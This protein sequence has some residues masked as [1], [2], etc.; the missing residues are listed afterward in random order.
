MRLAFVVPRFGP[1]VVGGVETHVRTLAEHLAARG[2]EAHVLTTTATDHYTWAPFHPEGTEVTGGVTVQRFDP[3]TTRHHGRFLEV[4]ARLS[5][6]APLSYLEQLEWI[7]QSVWSPG[8]QHHLERNADG[9]DWIVCAPYL[10]GTSYWATQV[11]PERTVHIPCVHDEPFAY[12]DVIREMLEDARGCLF[13][14]P[15]EADLALRLAPGIRRHAIGGLGFDAREPSPAAERRFLATNDLEPGYLFYAGRREPGKGIPRL[16]ELYGRLVAGRGRETTPPLVVA[17]RG[18]FDVPRELR[19]HV[20]D[21]GFLTEDEKWAA[22]RN[23]L[24]LVM[25]SRL[26]SLSIVTMEAWLAGTPVLVDSAS[27][28]VRDHCLRSGGGIP[29]GGLAQFAE[30][31]GMLVESPDLRAGLAA[32]GRRY[33]ESVY[34]WPAV[35]NRIETA[36]EAWA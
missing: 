29:Y 34:A 30:A 6:G 5:A 19:R 3:S 4:Q 31:V 25:P 27:L 32:N 13:N 33:V 15:G 12:Q 28:V 26:E 14:A 17:G 2:H 11:R 35:C 1:G 18:E 20:V 21:V 7:G 8:L 36:L 16:I 22:L 9:Y 10:F 24:C 23:A